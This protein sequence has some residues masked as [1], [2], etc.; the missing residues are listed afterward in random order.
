M[1]VSG[2]L[3]VD[4][5]IYFDGGIY[6]NGSGLTDIDASSIANDSL[7]FDKFVDAMITIATEAKENPA[8]LRSAPHRVGLKRLDETAA[9]RKPALT[10]NDE[11]KTGK[12]E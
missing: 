3:E 12:S 9:A 10:W 6:G 2:N 4:G 11:F 1:L 7:D 8:H 5:Y